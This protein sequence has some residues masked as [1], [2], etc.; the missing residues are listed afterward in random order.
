[1]TETEAVQG[2]VDRHELRELV[3]HTHTNLTW[4]CFCGKTGP[5]FASEESARHAHERHQDRELGRQGVALSFRPRL[6][7]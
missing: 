7:P 2:A 6:H 5:D 3:Y 1:M 4:W